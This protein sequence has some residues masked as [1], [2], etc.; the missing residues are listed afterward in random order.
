MAAQ[1][2]LV[3]NLL[4]RGREQHLFHVGVLED[5]HVVLR[6]EHLQALVQRH[7]PQV[8]TLVERAA[9]RPEARGGDEAPQS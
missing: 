3:P 9:E 7:A 4:Q 1:E 2:R 5:A 8:Q 6:P